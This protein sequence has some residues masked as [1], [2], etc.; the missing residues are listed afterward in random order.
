MKGAPANYLGRLVS[1]E[2]FRA[3]I[4]APDG[5]QI[6][7]ESWADFESKMESGLWFATKEDAAASV[8]VIDKPKPKTRQPKAKKID[9]PVEFEDA[10]DEDEEIDSVSEDAAF[11]VTGDDFL[12]KASK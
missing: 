7:V 3:F 5:G 4:Y 6:L 2:K 8:A 1:K 10:V 12:P 11:E 9:V